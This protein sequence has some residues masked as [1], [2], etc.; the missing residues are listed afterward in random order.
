MQDALLLLTTLRWISLWFDPSRL[1]YFT[2]FIPPFQMHARALYALAD[3]ICAAQSLVFLRDDA[4]RD[5]NE[6]VILSTIADSASAKSRDAIFVLETALVRLDDHIAEG[7]STISSSDDAHFTALFSEHSRTL[8]LLEALY[9][10]TRGWTY[11]PSNVKELTRLFQGALTSAEVVSEAWSAALACFP[12][13]PLFR[14]VSWEPKL[15]LLEAAACNHVAVARFVLAEAN[16]DGLT[17]ITNEVRQYIEKLY[18]SARVPA[19]IYPALST[20]RAIRS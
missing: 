16:T 6:A 8:Q 14:E 1:F 3:G 7:S 2:Y 12:L 13:H 18:V 17:E 9:D 10:H 4:T 15:V 5:V 11:A 19:T 20:R